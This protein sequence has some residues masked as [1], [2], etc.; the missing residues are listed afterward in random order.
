[1]ADDPDICVGKQQR[2]I[3]VEV[4]EKSRMSINKSTAEEVR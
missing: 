4:L 1:M 2:N 3:V